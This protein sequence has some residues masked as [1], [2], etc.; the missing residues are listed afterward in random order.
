MKKT[1]SLTSRD[2]AGRLGVLVISGVRG[3]RDVDTEELLSIEERD[4]TEPRF[5]RG[6]VE[7][8]MASV[9]MLDNAALLSASTS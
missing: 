5:L 2:S 8:K 1:S 3:D 9:A 4:L 6:L 7:P